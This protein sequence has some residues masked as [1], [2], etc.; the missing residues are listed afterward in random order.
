MVC[1]MAFFLIFFTLG[2]SAVGGAVWFREMSLT[3]YLVQSRVTCAEV[4]SV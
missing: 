3:M 1:G 4:L 2:L